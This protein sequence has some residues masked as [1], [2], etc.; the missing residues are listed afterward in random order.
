MIGSNDR[1]YPP[2]TQRE[3][4]LRIAIENL[5]DTIRE[6]QNDV[7]VMF[8]TASGLDEH[9]AEFYYARRYAPPEPCQCS[10]EARQIPTSTPALMIGGKIVA[11]YL[12][13]EDQSD[14]EDDDQGG[15]E[16]ED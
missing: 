13:G 14:P 3:I 12:G 15:P 10:E 8:Y 5:R 4:H 16:D 1:F 7:K 2:E 11:Q 6:L 9:F